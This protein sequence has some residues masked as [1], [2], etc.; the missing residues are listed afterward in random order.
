MR[1]LDVRLVKGSAYR[2]FV[3]SMALASALV[4]SGV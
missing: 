3:L 4:H 2:M 1:L